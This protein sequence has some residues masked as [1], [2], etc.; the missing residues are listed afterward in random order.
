MVTTVEGAESIKSTSETV[1]VTVTVNIVAEPVEL[2]AATAGNKKGNSFGKT[3]MIIE[4][5]EAAEMIVNPT[6]MSSGRSSGRRT[7][8][9]RVAGGT[10]ISAVN[11]E[12]DVTTRVQNRAKSK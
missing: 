5:S 6:G 10:K 2:A 12:I 7:M 4:K 11:V 8:V 9:E 1:T 3:T